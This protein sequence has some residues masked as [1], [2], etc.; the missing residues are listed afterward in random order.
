MCFKGLLQLRISLTVTAVR[1]GSMAFFAI[2]LPVSS[3]HLLPFPLDDSGMNSGSSW[4]LFQDVGA[5]TVIG[6][7]LPANCCIASIGFQFHSKGKGLSMAADVGGRRL[8]VDPLSATH[9]QPAE[10]GTC[11]IGPGEKP[12][13][14]AVCLLVTTYLGVLC[15]CPDC[16]H[17]GHNKFIAL[18]NQMEHPRIHVAAG[19][20]VFSWINADH[21]HNGSLT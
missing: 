14:M 20:T 8:W 3:L 5:I 9:N 12:S 17:L 21:T 6:P 11:T 10:L 13:F 19:V 1:P 2:G 7:Q 18:V 15:T 4:S 16:L